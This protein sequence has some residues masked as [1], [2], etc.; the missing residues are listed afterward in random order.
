MKKRMGNLARRLRRI[1]LLV[2][3]LSL[4]V[5]SLLYIGYE[6]YSYR[7]ALADR[8]TS[9]ARIIA[10]NATASLSFEDRKTA[11]KLLESLAIEQGMSAAVLYLPDGTPFASFYRD[12]RVQQVVEETDSEWLET[13]PQTLETRQRYDSDDFDLLMP[14]RLNGDIIG[15][16]FIEASLHPLYQRIYGFLGIAV[17]LFVLIMIGAW[18]LSSRLQRHISRP[19]EHLVQGMHRVAEKQDFHLR[20]PPGGNDEIGLL[21]ERFN[22]MLAQIEERER[23]LDSYREE[24]EQKVEE[25]TASLLEAKEAAEAASRAKSE[26]LATMSHEI[27]TPMNGVLG[28]TE[29]L[30]DSGL[31]VRAHRLAVTA[32]RSAESLLEIINDILDFSKIE[33]G[34]LELEETSF[35]LRELLED[36]LEL[37]A[38]QSVRKGIECIAD[39]PADLPGVVRGD[40][41]RLRQVLSNLL[42]NAVKFTE[43]GE[44]RLAARVLA[45][46]HEHWRIRF[47]VCD[48]GI[49]IEADKQRQIFN[50]FSQADGSTT[51]RFGGTGLGLA[52]AQRLVMLM[53]GDIHLDSEPGRGSCFSFELSMGKADER[54]DDNACPELLRD[55]RV[56]IVDDHPVNRQILDEHTRSWGMRPGTADS[57]R[58]ALQLLHRAETEGKPYRLLL[59]DL[60][61]P[62]MDGL[63]LARLIRS[64]HS[65]EPP[66]MVMLSS[67]QF[68][69]DSEQ[70]RAAGIAR[71]LQKP[72]R[73]RQLH[74]TLCDLLGS[75]PGREEAIPE[76]VPLHGRVLLAE[77][78]IVNQEVAIGML[79]QMG[80]EV[81]TAGNGLEAVELLREQDFDLVLMDCHMPEMDGFEATRKIRQM[82]RARGRDAIPILALTADVQKGIQEQCRAVGMDGYLSKP[83]TRQALQLALQP[84]LGERSPVRTAAATAAVPGPAVASVID[85][86]ALQALKR[87]SEDTGRDIL[88]NALRH[89]LERCPQDLEAMEQAWQAGDGDGLRQLAHA[90]KSAAANLGLQEFSGRCKL[91]EQ[92]G[93]LGQ[94]EGL[95]EELN[96]LRASWP[97]IEGRLRTDWLPDDAARDQAVS[98]GSEASVR[99]PATGPLI[100]LVDDDA[101]YRATIRELLEGH[102]MRVLE[103][104]SGQKALEMIDSSQPELVMLDALMPEMDGFETCRRIRRQPRWRFLPIMMVTGLDDLESVDRAFESG[105]TSFIPKPVRFS[106]LIHRIRFQLRVAQTTR[107]LHENQQRLSSVQRLAKLGY[108]RWEADEDRF[109][110]SEHLGEMIACCEDRAFHSLEDYL[111]HIHPED[112]EYIRNQ[113]QEVARGG[114]PQSADYRLL[115]RRNQIRIVHQLLA[116]VPEEPGVILGTVQDITEQRASEQRIRQL[117]YTDVL[118]GLASRAYFHKHLEDVIRAAHR[119]DERFALLYLDLD[120]FKDVN[121]SLGHDVGDDLLRIVASRLQ[122]VLRETDFVARLSGDEFCILVDN[123]GD[124]YDAADVAGRTLEALNQPVELGGQAMR[125]RCSI[126]IAYY[127]E[128]GQDAQTLLKAADSAMYAAK[129]EGKHR[130]A[131]YQPEFTEKAKHRLKMEQ[132]LRQVLETQQDQLELHYQP[133]ID[134]DSGRISGVE[135]LVRW[136]H[137]Q[138]GLLSPL[139]FIGVA[140]RIGVIDQLGN[141][142]LSKACRQAADWRASGLPEFRIAV[143]ISPLQFNDP[144]LPDSVRHALDESGLP[145]QWLELEVTESVVQTSGDNLEAFERIRA[146]GVK[147]AIDDFG[148]GYSSLASLKYLP[149]D[150]LKIDR[151]F[152]R[153]MLEDSDSAVLLGTIV[154]V[155]HALGHGV[156]AEGVEEEAQV[157]VLRGLGCDMIQGYYFSR[158]VP[159]DQVPALAK[160]NFLPPTDRS[161]T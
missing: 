137:P 130:Y 30:L 4:F 96:L 115:T 110:T 13:L 8:I 40:A 27:R 61:M 140:E 58:K 51:R 84:W 47:E 42:G 69:A 136:R 141:L 26:F 68:D 108:W 32:H 57:A 95:D 88:G 83:F 71:H 31:D 20:L 64:D 135:A 79:I 153:D 35:E 3:G 45:E 105:A 134:L 16:L 43:K 10:T 91:I 73:R 44:I 81:D 23:Q 89:F 128:D 102:G 90:L 62:D 33:A 48:T 76:E 150:S 144:A 34:K 39:L 131:F 65:L 21:I 54:I 63:E 1:I 104:D 66:L 99:E 146:L 72:L 123:V 12:Q 94:L 18:W 29:L 74:E 14:V 53:G 24:L 122:S 152:I 97:D 116:I 46:E 117:A 127:P 160:K 2:T 126:G 109:S 28:M 87:L 37:Y 5:A 100:L 149:I 145:A 157:R 151:L 38:G 7:N 143:N 9:M 133:Q 19:V 118:T 86:S 156:V 78:N 36:E 112:Q 124:Q 147:L 60:H 92:R 161:Q 125:P 82:E 113:I 101:G 142:V 75:T 59:T 111:S 93:R 55:I 154:G 103:A 49:G 22:D 52:I 50:A 98:V 85:E 120:A 148:T 6:V 25:R 132:E 138:R 17:A 56:L 11:Q 121:D 114:E 129:E 80:I 41:T 15:Y 107:E 159:A 70:M 155:A 77:D 67:T 158:P 106:L 139:E 119:R